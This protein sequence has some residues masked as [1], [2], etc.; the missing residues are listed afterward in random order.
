MEEENQNTASDDNA[1]KGD[2]KEATVE[3]ILGTEEAEK[4]V[5]PLIQLFVDGYA[6]RLGP[7]GNYVRRVE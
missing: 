6:Y 7:Y 2:I 4:S 3:E 5:K 1:Q